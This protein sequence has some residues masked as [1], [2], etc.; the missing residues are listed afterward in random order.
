MKEQLARGTERTSDLGLP[1]IF[2]SKIHSRYE[3]VS[4]PDLNI[5]NRGEKIEIFKLSEQKE[6]STFLYNLLTLN[7]RHSQQ[8]N[9][10]RN[11]EDSV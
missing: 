11:T 9:L 5:L 8:L 3:A 7:H 2:E 1:K 10:G 6:I 4:D